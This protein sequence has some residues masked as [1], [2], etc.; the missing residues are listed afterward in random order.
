M[1]NSINTNTLCLRMFWDVF[2]CV[3]E[4]S[5]KGKKYKKKN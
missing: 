1:K 5:S 2:I 4:G 3:C